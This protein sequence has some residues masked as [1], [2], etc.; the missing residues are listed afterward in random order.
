[1][2]TAKLFRNGIAMMITAANLEASLD[3]QSW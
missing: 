2:E 3:F 1:M